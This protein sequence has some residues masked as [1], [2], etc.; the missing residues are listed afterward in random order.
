MCWCSRFLLSI[1]VRYRSISDRIG[2]FSIS[3]IT[4]FVSPTEL[5]PF[6]FP[7]PNKNMK[8]KMVRVFSRPIPTAFIPTDG[9]A[10]GKRSWAGLGW[11]GT[12]GLLGLGCVRVRRVR[13]GGLLGRARELGWVLGVGVGVECLFY[14]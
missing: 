9:V 2:S 10:R 8:T 4:N 11:R 6:L 5:F 12:W 7:F 1:L 14:I 3:R 13:L